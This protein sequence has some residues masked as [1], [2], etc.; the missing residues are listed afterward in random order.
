M[1]CAACKKKEATVH[2]T[3]I[4]DDKIVKLHLCEDCSRE[5][6]LGEESSPEI[7]DLL[8]SL[9]E[10]KTLPGQED[11]RCPDCGIGFAD[12]RKEGR[13][14]C[15]GCYRAFSDGLVSLISN[16][17]H[18]TRHTGKTPAAFRHLK[19]APDLNRLKA[20]LNRAIREEDFEAAARLRDRIRELKKKPPPP[21][22]DDPAPPPKGDPDG[23]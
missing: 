11:T 6:G 18:Q 5:K 14:G 7:H 17:Q 10:I 21:P 4:T 2:F 12:F 16:I 19:P 9:A 15:A 13:L 20:D 23:D 8:S 3:E 22:G 1:L